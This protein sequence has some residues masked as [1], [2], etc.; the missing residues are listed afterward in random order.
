MPGVAGLGKQ[1]QIGK[2]EFLN[3]LF[4]FCPSLVV[5]SRT[6]QRMKEKH[7]GKGD[8]AADYEGQINGGFSQLVYHKN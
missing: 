4:F 2:A 8:N 7:K 3:Q 5:I 6:K 1:A